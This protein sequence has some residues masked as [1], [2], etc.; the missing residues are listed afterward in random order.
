[1]LITEKYRQLNQQLHQ[2]RSDYGTSG[3]KWAPLVLAMVNKHN[4]SSVLDYGAG[5][6]T[7]RNAMLPFEFEMREYDPAIPDLSGHPEPADL[8]VSTDMLEH[9]EPECLSAVL[10]DIERCAKRFV[11]L[12]V[13]TRPAVKFLADGRNAHLIVQPC[14]WWL[15]RLEFR[16]KLLRIEGNAGE[17]MFFGA[18][19]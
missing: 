14:S 6:R 3:H 1:M 19:Q 7:L 13:A 16:W 18:T 8:V 11:F 2:D 5:K 10:G 9:V 17:F 15:Q 12:T 4:L